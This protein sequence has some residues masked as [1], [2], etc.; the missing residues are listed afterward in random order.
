MTDGKLQ[1]ELEVAIRLARQAGEAIMGYYQT[2]LEV[3]E[4]AGGEPVTAADRAAD[5]LIGAGLR[6]A[7]PLDG[8]LTEESDD[9]PSR[10]DKERVWIVDPLDGTTE[11]INETGDFAVQIALA[12]RGQPAL[13]V[14]YQPA[15]QLLYHAVQGSGAYCVEDGTS[16]RL[17][18]S[19]RT[20]PA[21]MCM[22]ASRSHYSELVESARRAFGI[23]RV[24]HVGSV[25]LKAGLVAQGTC[26]LYVATTVAKEWDVC[27][28][29][30]LLMEAG[31][32][33][34]NLC[35]DRPVYNQAE[36]AECRG[37]IGSNGQV[38]ARLVEVVSALMDEQSR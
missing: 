35:G 1:H 24:N 4:K 14:V 25:G 12:V 20:D 16:R 19:A 9:D 15:A 3:L 7:F 37:L 13:G 17:M 2:G 5:D 31:G 36:V 8:L 22:V 28:P 26:D 27:A 33:L 21:G 18:V 38:H 30:A 6:A 32:T 34:T 11:F 10:L 23:A 29:H